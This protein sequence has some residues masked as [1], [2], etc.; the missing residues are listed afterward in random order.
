MLREQVM[1]QRKALMLAVVIAA[2]ASGGCGGKSYVRTSLGKQH[3]S[4]P[5][6][7]RISEKRSNKEREGEA[8]AQRDVAEMQRYLVEGDFASVKKTAIALLKRNPASLEAHTYLAVALDKFD[9]PTGA[10]QHYLRAAELAP[11]NGGMLGN[12]GIWLCE[13]GR[14]DDALTWFDRALALPNFAD[15]PVIL[16]NSGA[17]ADK[18]GQ[19]QRAER[20]LRRAIELDPE[21]PVALAALAA[22]E[23]K[24]GDAFEARA[25]R[26]GVSLLHQPTRK[27]C[28]LR[29]KSNKNSATAVPLR[30]TFRD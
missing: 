28:C 22:R 10:G 24:A 20:D 1:P 12:Y 19:Q 16:A 15:S 18:V 29:H 6:V 3:Y 13:Q 21:N 11:T 30:A 23:F 2:I 14:V 27:R 5:A 7:N 17:C 9:D 26:N 25:F 8:S 4:E